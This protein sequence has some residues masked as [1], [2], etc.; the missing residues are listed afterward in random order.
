MK[1]ALNNCKHDG[2]GPATGMV[3]AREAIAISH[4]SESHPV[5]PDDIIIASGCSGALELV[6]SVLLNAGDNLLVPQP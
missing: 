1:D 3:S 2:Y 6:V 4:S 5:S